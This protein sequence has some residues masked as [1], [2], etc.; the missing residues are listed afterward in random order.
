LCTLVSVVREI[1]PKP[2][3]SKVQP[4]AAAQLLRALQYTDHGYSP[5]K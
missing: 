3:L 4:L 5:R 1:D 2:M